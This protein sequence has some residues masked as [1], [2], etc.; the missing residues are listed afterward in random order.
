[1]CFPVCVL[2][3]RRVP[4]G[5]DMGT[6][7][8]PQKCGIFPTAWDFSHIGGK[9]KIL[10]L[11]N[12]K[13]MPLLLA[14]NLTNKSRKKCPP[15]FHPPPP[16]GEKFQFYPLKTA[17][18]CLFFGRKVDKLKERK[19]SPPPPLL[20]PT[21]RPLAPSIQPPPLSTQREK[22]QLYPLKTANACLFYWQ[23]I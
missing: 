17:H 3:C 18:S 20:P 11:K 10:P 15:P 9:I 6:C 23:G 14:G 19:M 13:C 12:R 8:P 22:S 21:P 2:A 1:M 7:P 5:G 4:R 16:Q